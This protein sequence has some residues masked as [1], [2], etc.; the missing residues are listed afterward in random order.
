MKCTKVFEVLFY[1]LCYAGAIYYCHQLIQKYLLNERATKITTR[2]LDL[3]ECRQPDCY[4][5]ATICLTFLSNYNDD[6]D[7]KMCKF[8]DLGVPI[9]R[10]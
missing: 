2:Q 9:N 8:D 6:K 3:K 7:A 4:P 10:E 1:I 5:S